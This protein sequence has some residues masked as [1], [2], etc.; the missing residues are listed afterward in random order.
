MTVKILRGYI[1]ILVYEEA[2]MKFV[3]SLQ[4]FCFK[5]YLKKLRD[6]FFRKENAVVGSIAT[7]V[8]VLWKTFVEFTG[9]RQFQKS[10]KANCNRT[11]HIL[12]EK[13]LINVSFFNYFSYTQLFSNID[14]IKRKKV[15]MSLTKM[16]STIC[17]FLMQSLLSNLQ[18]V[19]NV[20]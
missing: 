8:T 16:Q 10:V 6:S 7:V 1:M 15:F 12:T 17:I 5:T 4:N 2:V 20:K 3:I 11:F 13:L 14:P 9:L 19:K 18:V